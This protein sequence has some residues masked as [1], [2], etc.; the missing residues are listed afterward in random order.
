MSLFISLARTEDENQIAAHPVFQ[1]HRSVST[2]YSP[3][4]GGKK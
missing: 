4:W 2:N 3:N 1:Q